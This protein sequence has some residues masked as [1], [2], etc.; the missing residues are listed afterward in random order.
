MNGVYTAIIFNLDR[1]MYYQERQSSTNLSVGARQ[2]FVKKVYSVLSV[3]LLVTVFMVWCNYSFKAF[4]RYQARN[5][6]LYWV[7]MIG[8]IVS[9]I[10]LRKSLFIQLS[11]SSHVPSLPTTQSWPYSPSAN[12]TWFHSFAAFTHHKASFSQQ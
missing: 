10:T 2:S 8:T 1:S 4:A 5:T 11:E 6:W 3:Q 12:R 7:A 9:L